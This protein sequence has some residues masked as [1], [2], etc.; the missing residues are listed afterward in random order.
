MSVRSRNRSLLLFSRIYQS[1]TFRSISKPYAMQTSQ[2]DDLHRL[3]EELALPEVK[4]SRERR[5][6]ICRRALKLVSP[7]L[8][9]QR[10]EL[11]RELGDALFLD[12]SGSRPDS[13]E[14][15]VRCFQ[16]AL[17]EAPPSLPR[18]KR[19]Q[20]LIRLGDSHRNR[21]RGPRADNVE[22]AIRS[23]REAIAWLDRET[24]VGSW[25]LL[26]GSL[27]MAWSER[28]YGD[29]AENVEL[30]IA[31]YEQALEVF[32][33][34]RFPIE[35][36]VTVNNLAN[37]YRDR[38]RGDPADNLERAIRLY[39]EALEVRRRETNAVQWAVTVHNLAIACRRRLRGRPEDNM[40]RSI[41]LALKALE[42]RT[43]ENTPVRWA[44]TQ[45]ALGNA[46]AERRR[47]DF[48]ENLRRAREAYEG[49]LE[50]LRPLSP[51]QAA[52]ILRNLGKIRGLLYLKHGEGDIEAALSACHAALEIN[53][54][55]ADPHE[56]RE[57]A[58]IL[59]L[60]LFG[61]PRW[62]EAAEAFLSALRAGELLYQAGAT[63]ESRHA[64]L[65]EG[66]DL[67]ARAAYSLA[68]AGRWAEA[69]ET[70]ERS[71]TRALGESL[72]RNEALL[73]RVREEHRR[74]FQ[75]HR[76]RIRALEAEA[77]SA[78]PAGRSFLEIS[79]DLR[80]VRQELRDL[81][82]VIRADVPDF[83]EEGLRFTGICEL[84]TRLGQPLVQIMNVSWGGLALIVPP[85]AE[86]PEHV[87]AVWMRGL[88]REE[89]Q[90]LLFAGDHPL[91][92][93]DE[94]GSGEIKAALAKAWPILQEQ[95]VTPVAEALLALGFDRSVLLPSGFLSLLPLP[96]LAIDRVLLT[97]APSARLLQAAASRARER[98]D[99]PPAFLGVGTGAPRVPLPSA[100]R[101]VQGAASVF[102]P[103][104][105]R[106]LLEREVGRTA[107]LSGMAGASH[108][109]F[110]CHGLF[111]PAAPLESALHLG[112]DERLTLRDLLDGSPDLTAA[113]LAVLSACRSGL[114]EYRD[115]PDEALGFPAVLLQAGIPAVVGTLWPVADLSSALLMDRFYELH[116]RESQPVAEALRSAQR[117]LRDATAAELGLAAR[118]EELL[119]QARTPS[120]RAAAY[121]MLRRVRARPELCPYSHPYY[122]AGYV[123]TGDPGGTPRADTVVSS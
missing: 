117:W 80:T 4:R 115:A 9:W 85:G 3:L 88:S 119:A 58:E 91:L 89:T 102:S 110:A 112:N 24:D 99:F 2:P 30:A 37:V 18:E 8:M 52:T 35:W 77:R 53:P 42:V 25:A 120:E 86:A 41:E 93:Q 63:P 10:S 27:G 32:T 108:L 40:D 65:R 98:R 55:E 118:S 104:R 22:E 116:L 11:W 72:D 101:E 81:T 6:D 23:Y 29:R 121:Q 68:R 105:R 92:P 114:V 73:E 82:E 74:A 46:W 107:V 78:G 103:D 57:A 5:A 21:L 17:A 111:D 106:L 94:P 83:F 48:A 87:Q 71:R 90:E 69:V 14:E 39:E 45:C 43:R 33:R 109:H 13:V 31:A 20:L 28:V 62:N 36:G 64:E 49:A 122:W 26:Q 47:G 60:N 70:L 19:A 75:E 38:L 51:F 67:A 97:S 44:Q 16:A 76:E 54:V 12:V 66:G 7:D 15:A 34:D 56:Y 96:A 50:V 61:I 84:A 79:A 100:L 1:N 113:R 59:G 95:I 123:L